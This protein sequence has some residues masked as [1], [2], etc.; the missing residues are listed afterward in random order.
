MSADSPQVT[1]DGLL[2][3]KNVTGLRYLSLGGL[4]AGWLTKT[5]LDGVIHNPQLEWLQLGR[6]KSLPEDFML[7]EAV[8]RSVRDGCGTETGSHTHP[9]ADIH[10]ARHGQYYRVF[11]HACSHKLKHS[12]IHCWTQFYRY[13]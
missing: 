8:I 12:H 5:L 9:D 2:H 1:D 10:T 3:L 11:S 6:P 13:P 7:V 4:A